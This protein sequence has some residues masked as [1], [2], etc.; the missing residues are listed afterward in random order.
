LKVVIYGREIDVG[1]GGNV[2]Q[3]RDVETFISKQLLGG[4][5]NPGFGI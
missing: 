5:E 4:V 2:A 1:F 3:G